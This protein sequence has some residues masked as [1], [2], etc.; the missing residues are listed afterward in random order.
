MNTF[1]C[2]TIRVNTCL[3]TSNSFLDYSLASTSVIGIDSNFQCILA[4]MKIHSTSSNI[5]L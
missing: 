5:H 4:D 2:G 3:V 1:Y